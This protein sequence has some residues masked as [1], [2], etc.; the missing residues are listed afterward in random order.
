MGWSGNRE[1]RD[2]RTKRKREKEKVALFNVYV[3]ERNNASFTLAVQLR[4]YEHLVRTMPHILILP[5]KKVPH[6]DT[7]PNLNGSSGNPSLQLNY[8]SGTGA[9][10][11]VGR[12]KSLLVTGNLCGRK[13]P[14][15]WTT[16]RAAHLS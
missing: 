15:V 7:Y 1:R 3:F 13:H 5:V 16:A 9:G 11:E 6:T 2:E 12:G 4:D 14:D 10:P 8:W